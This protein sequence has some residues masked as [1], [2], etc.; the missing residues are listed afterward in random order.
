M[1]RLLPLVLL[2]LFASS[3]SSADTFTE[4]NIAVVDEHIVPSYKELVRS[5]ARLKEYGEKLCENGDAAD[6]V[7]VRRGYNDVM[8]QWQV[9]QKW[10]VGPDRSSIVHMRFHMWPE[11]RS[12]VVKQVQA[13]LKAAS[14]NALVSDKLAESSPAIQGIPALQLLL[15][16]NDPQIHD[17]VESGVAAYQCQ[18]VLAVSENLSRIAADMLDKWSH[19][20]RNAFSTPGQENPYFPSSN[21]ATNHLFNQYLQLITTVHNAKLSY[22]LGIHYDGKPRYRRTESRR[23]KRSLR[24]VRINVISISKFYAISRKHLEYSAPQ[25]LELDQGWAA[26]NEILAQMPD[27][28]ESA[29]SQYPDQMLEL[30]NLLSNM[31][32]LAGGHMAETLG[33]HH[34]F[35]DT[36]G[37]D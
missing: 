34:K 20:Y 35:N 30:V 29:Y 5:T 24:N 28:M 25:Q 3:N 27:E 31:K 12:I 8:D 11:G 23:S 36:D 15:Y 22:P 7:R 21:V 33:F 6:L 18:Y 37:D 1:S 26:A 32:D 14:P 4:F 17:F 16:W 2:S 19:A 9:L 10:T 13:V